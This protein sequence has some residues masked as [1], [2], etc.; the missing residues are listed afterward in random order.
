MLYND[1]A[2]KLDFAKRSTVTRVKVLIITDDKY[3]RRRAEIELSGHDASTSI[4]PSD[5]DVILYDTASSAPC[6]KSGA[7][8]VPIGR[9]DGEKNKLP[10]PLGEIKRLCE[11]GE[12]TSRLRLSDDGRSVYLDGERIKLTRQEYSLLS[13]L[14]AGGEQ[15][16]TREEISK[17][18]WESAEDGLI[19]IYIHY[20]RKKLER[21]GEKVIISSR[22]YGYK[23]DEKFLKEDCVCFL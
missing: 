17:T 14:I 4:H 20:L 19:N 23:I 3:L 5:A 9:S 12:C 15:F 2:N 10:L 18:A 16:T 6:P 22:S 7:R 21:S 11:R 13:I 8:T 1:F